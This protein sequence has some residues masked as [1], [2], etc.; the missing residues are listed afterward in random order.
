MTEQEKKEI[1]GSIK[2]SWAVE[3]LAISGEE[4]KILEEILDDKIPIEQAIAKIEQKHIREG[5]IKNAK[6]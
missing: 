2:T 1:I 5:R 4:Q 6:V 3:G